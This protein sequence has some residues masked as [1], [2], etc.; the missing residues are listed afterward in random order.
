MTAAPK[1]AP[2][3]AAPMFPLI[4]VSAGTTPR[5][6]GRL[7]GE[8]AR[9]QCAIS[10]ATY[11]R[12]FASCGID[13]A[14]ACSRAL[15]YREVIAAMDADLLD[16]MAGI[17]EGAGLD[18]A[19][20]LALNC[21]TEILPPTFLG[22][23]DPVA[24]ARAL[25]AN[26]ALGLPDWL[27]GAALDPAAAD[28]ECTAMVVAASASRDGHTWFSQ[29]WDW[30]GRQ[31]PALV[32][33]RSH[34]GRGTAF[35][36][37]TEGGMLAKIGLNQ[38][39]FA[40]GLNILRSRGDGAKPGVAVH[41]L[42]RHLLSSPTLAHA[43]RVLADLQQRLGFGAASNIPCA[44]ATGDVACFEVAPAGWG[45]CRPTDGVV[46]HSNHFLCA[47][48]QPEQVAPSSA[49][50]TELRLATAQRHAARRPLDQAALEAFLRDETD[51]LLSVCRSPDPALPPEARV[52]SVAGVVIDCEA[53]AMWVA[54]DVPSRAE[55]QRVA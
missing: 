18:I 43:R 21:R 32:L 33:L 49:L 31:R 38:H 39:G 2:G 53:R 23:S 42:L 27:D 47:P 26:Q 45:E 37:L 16:E 6:R 4:D 20:V 35:T 7:Y 14:T 24:A 34:D 44:D 12:L 36:T 19:E 11:A 9:P 30:I 51:G 5:A 48:L 13:W 17:A 46:V 1:T 52:E 55:F 29:N 22:E 3:A 25:A 10:R 54:P 8:A 15:A 41:V 40:L 50:S 28:G